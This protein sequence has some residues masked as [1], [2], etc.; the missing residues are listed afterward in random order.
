MP[1]TPKKCEEC[2]EKLACFG[3]PEG[4]KSH[5]GKCKSDVMID[6]HHKSALC[7]VCKKVG[8]TFGEPDKK[9]THCLKCKKEDMLRVRQD[10]CV[11]CNNKYRRFGKLGE[12]ALYCGDCKKEG[13][14]DS[15]V[16][17]CSIC[18]KGRP[19][20]ANP[21]S[22]LGTHCNKCKTEEMVNVRSKPCEGCKV[23]LPTF[24]VKGGKITHC[25]KCKSDDMINL[26]D[27]YCTVC[28]GKQASFAEKKGMR[29][30]HCATCKPET[31]FKSYKVCKNNICNIEATKKYNGYCTWCF[32]HLF[33]D[34]PLSKTIRS[35]TMESEVAVAVLGRDP[36]YKQDKPIILGG[37]D[38]SVRRRVDFWK[39]IG[40]TVVAIE[41]DEYQHKG[42]DI[43]KE[44]IR[45]DDLYMA[46]SGKWVFIRFNPHDYKCKNG[47]VIKRKLKEKL[48]ELIAEIEKH[49]ER[50]RKEQNLE[51]LE[52]HKLFFDEN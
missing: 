11:E 41:V 51:L 37:C 22:K 13:M 43:Q 32:Q 21:G 24:G 19:S 8:A 9:P 50:I 23:T 36:E 14:I 5:C 10:K 52:I 18:K 27:P 45:Y 12:K 39:I 34:D 3:L 31:Y 20:H 30:T 28:K 40:N 7:V 2:K 26:K 29:P 16:I 42:Y 25:S 4:K 38:C 46:F 17:S 33:P 44:E 35:K 15:S 1:G 47:K 49:E 6:L 48:P